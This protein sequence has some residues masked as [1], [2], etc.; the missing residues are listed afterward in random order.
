MNIRLKKVQNTKQQ[1]DDRT[2]YRMRRIVRGQVYQQ[3]L[4]VDPIFLHERWH[5]ALALCEARR[6]LREFIKREVRA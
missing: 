4:A 1:Y 3:Q 6:E 2:V 5:V